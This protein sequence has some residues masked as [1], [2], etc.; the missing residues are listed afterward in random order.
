M[1]DSTNPS[2]TEPPP[3][4]PASPRPTGAS[5][6][7]GW[8]QFVMAIAFIAG[9]GGA[10]GGILLMAHSIPHCFPNPYNDVFNSDL[11]ECTGKDH[12]FVGAGA[13]VLVGSVIQGLVIGVLAKVCLVTHR[14][15]AAIDALTSDA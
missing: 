3:E 4:P 6:L 10:L 7:E 9:V 15:Q 14:Q 13:A 11:T 8:G 1:T 2:G 5:S 12:P